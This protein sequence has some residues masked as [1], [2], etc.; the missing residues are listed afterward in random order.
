MKFRD[1]SLTFCIDSSSITS[2]FPHCQNPYNLKA[3]T[4]WMLIFRYHC[5]SVKPTTVTFMKSRET[6][7]GVFINHLLVLLHCCHQSLDSV[8]DPVLSVP[9]IELTIDEAASHLWRLITKTF[10]DC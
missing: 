4:P 9:Y 1:F 5:D 8:S 10:L 7:L 3:I 2:S 6:Q